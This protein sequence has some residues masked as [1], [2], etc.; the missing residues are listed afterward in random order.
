MHSGMA[1][2]QNLAS[3]PLIF[4]KTPG[5]DTLLGRRER[6]A[7]SFGL[8]SNLNR[9]AVCDSLF[10]SHLSYWERMKSQREYTHVLDAP[11]FSVG[12]GA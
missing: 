3:L 11:L 4:N 8:P 10:S 1:F 9:H 6:S 5:P 7:A 12:F 2:G